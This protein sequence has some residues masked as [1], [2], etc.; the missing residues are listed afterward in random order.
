MGIRFEILYEENSNGMYFTGQVVKGRALIHVDEEIPFKGIQLRVRGYA[1]VRWDE[2]SAGESSDIYFDDER[3]FD[4]LT[5]CI[6]TK[7]LELTLL[8]GTYTYTFEC[9]LPSECPSSFE[10]VYGLIRYDTKITVIRPRAFNKSYKMAFSVLKI[11]DL[12]HLPELRVPAKME[13]FKHFCCGPCRSKPLILLLEIQ[14]T[15]FVPGEIIHFKAKFFNTSSTVVEQIRVTLNLVALYSVRNRIRTK[16]EKIV[17]AKK[18]FGAFDSNTAQFIDNLQVPPTPPTCVGL[19]PIIKISYEVAATAKVKGVHI[20][21]IV[22]IPITIGNVPYVG[23]SDNI[24]PEDSLIANLSR[25]IAPIQS[26]DVE[27]PP[28]TYEEAH[29]LRN[30][31]KGTTNQEKEAQIDKSSDKFYPRYPFYSEAAYQ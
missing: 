1:K 24:M 12:N 19:C 11:F 15:S 16:E 18:K 5:E 7:G 25:G 8:P 21:P 20:N 14:R 30:L 28:P 17:I 10:G 6:D 3:Y 2:S 26:P 29:F 23:Q 31:P 22:A 27:L 13:E 9:V 4:S